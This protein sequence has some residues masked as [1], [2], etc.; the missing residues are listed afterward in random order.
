MSTI[1][2]NE[3]GELIKVESLTPASRGINI[4]VKVVSIGEVRDVSRETHRIADA[5]VGDETGSIILT[6]WDD[7]IG[8]VDVDDTIKIG[9]GYIRL[10]RGSMRLNIGR[11]GSMDKMEEDVISEVNKENNLSDKTYE[12]RTPRFR[13]SYSDREPRRRSYGRPRRY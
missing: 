7:T 2:S 9:N 3:S 10:F 13:S 12:Q 1:G 6:L 8:Q 5:L 4:I 11:Y